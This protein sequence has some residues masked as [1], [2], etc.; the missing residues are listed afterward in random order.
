MKIYNEYS[1]NNMIFT[2]FAAI[3]ILSM[4]L[5]KWLGQIINAMLSKL[6]TNNKTKRNKG[7]AGLGS[8]QGKASSGISRFER[9]YSCSSSRLCIPKTIW[10]VLTSVIILNFIFNSAFTCI[11]SL[12]MHMLLNL[13][14][15]PLHT[16]MRCW[17][18][19]HGHRG[20]VIL[21]KDVYTFLNLFTLQQMSTKWEDL[22]Y[23]WRLQN[24]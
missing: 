2:I 16:D 4:I 17:R 7:T 22:K 21:R 6:Y 14:V 1:L 18:K 3:R 23:L 24:R 8:K 12:H 19:K 5:G 15:P 11:L 10:E 9:E 20:K 13:F